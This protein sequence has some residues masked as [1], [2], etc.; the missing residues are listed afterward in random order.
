MSW[1]WATMTSSSLWLPASPSADRVLTSAT[2]EIG[3]DDVEDRVSLYVLGECVVQFGVPHG[4][5]AQFLGECGMTRTA[6]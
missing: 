4:R 3:A 5:G 6:P 1:Y 2:L